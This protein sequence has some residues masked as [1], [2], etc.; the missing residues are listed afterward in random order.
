M[1]NSPEFELLRE[2]RE[3]L[4]ICSMVTQNAWPTVKWKRE[5]ASSFL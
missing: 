4:A 1:P 2:R 3:H 5:R